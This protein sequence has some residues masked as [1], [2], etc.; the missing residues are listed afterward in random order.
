MAMPALFSP[1]MHDRRKRDRAADRFD[2]TEGEYRAL[3][4]RHHSHRETILRARLQEFDEE[5]RPTLGIYGSIG[6]IG[7]RQFWDEWNANYESNM[8]RA[9]EALERA[10]DAYGE[11]GMARPSESYIPGRAA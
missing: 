6:G 9:W 7:Q 11:D 4:S 3:M 2:L 10:H 8:E 1:E 5:R